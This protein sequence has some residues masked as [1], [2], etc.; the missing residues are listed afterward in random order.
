MYEIKYHKPNNNTIDSNTKIIDAIKAL[1]NLSQK[2][3]LVVDKHK[4]LLGTITDG[5]VRRALLKSENL[6]LTCSKVMNSKPM[7]VVEKKSEIILELILKY[8]FPIPVVNKENGKVVSLCDVKPIN[9]KVLR[10]TI[11]IMAGGKGERLLP[12][13]KKTAKPMLPIR[14]KPLI[15]EILDNIKLYGFKNIVI[16]VNYLA[17]QL[18]DYFGDGSKFNVNIEYIIEKEPLGTA[19]SL[20]MLKSDL[21]DPIIIINGDVLTNLNLLKL[22]DFHNEKK[23]QITM[24]VANYSVSIP[25]GT[26]STTGFKVSKIIEKPTENY[27]VNAGIYV[28]NK[29][30]LK[31]IKKN[32]A[33]DMTDL[34][35]K[36]LKRNQVNAY[37]MFEDWTDIGS[38]N[39]YLKIRSKETK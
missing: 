32:T 20:S 26:I 15:H 31:S 14:E 3:L 28:I 24:C 10:N 13:T 6:N 9:N 38:I 12:L 25:Y 1:N 19:G 37:P 16:S 11:V 23:M 8:G 5:D 4:K 22:L 30:V 7:F 27:L 39:D 33:I 36:Y 17:K 21:D 18:I 29:S 2:V 35:D 34:I